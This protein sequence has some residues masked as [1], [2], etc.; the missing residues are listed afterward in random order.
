MQD[1]PLCMVGTLGCPKHAILL[2]PLQE[3]H[4]GEKWSEWGGNFCIGFLIGFHLPKVEDFNCSFF[5]GTNPKFQRLGPQNNIL[6]LEKLRISQKWPCGR[7]DGHGYRVEP[8]MKWDVLVSNELWCNK[9]PLSV[10]LRAHTMFIF[11]HNIVCFY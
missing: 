4:V 7:S 2:A 1:T 3:G 8:P 11:M 5:C 10:L 6:N 9:N